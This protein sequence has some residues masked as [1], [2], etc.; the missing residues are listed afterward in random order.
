MVRVDDFNFE[1]PE[2]LIAQHP[3]TERGA[4]RM[5]VLKRVGGTLREE[6]ER[7]AETLR[8]AE[9]L[10]DARFRDL[11]DFLRAGD[12]LVLNDSRVLPGR[13]FGRRA[14]AGSGLKAQAPTGAIEVLLTE[15][16][17]SPTSQNRDVGHPNIWRAL[18]RPGRKVRVG[19]R[20]EFLA[21]ESAEPALTAE[22]I[23]AG[24]R[25]ERTLRF[26]SM[27]SVEDFYGV[28]GRIGHMPLPPYIRHGQD[29]PEDRERYQTVY[30]QEAGSA[31]APTAGLHFTPEMLATLRARGV[32]I[33]TV[34]LHVGLGTFQ[35]VR[36]EHVEDVRLHAERYTMPVATAEAL[37]RALKEGRRVI[38]VGTTTTR[39]LE[40]IAREAREHVA[41]QAI[42]SCPGVNPPKQSLDGARNSDWVEKI[43]AHTGATAMFLAPG[44]RFRVVSGLVTNFHLPQSTLLMLVCAFAGQG[45]EDRDAG[46]RAVLAAYAHAIRESYRFYSYGDCMLVV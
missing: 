32:E 12:L 16:I 10:T 11:P 1:L 27:E 23:A 15:K 33:A 36:A 2:E 35:P 45:L 25:G 9:K 7:N 38:A 8:E 31:A 40:H 14:V 30:A 5:L 37:R 34:T 19:E 13:L 6:E 44:H 22:V 28:L 29:G 39:T 21:G 4:S 41:A 46:R 18:V 20:L 42:A 24:E 43:E 17:F 26:A 3:P